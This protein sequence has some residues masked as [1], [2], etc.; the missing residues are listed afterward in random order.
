VDEKGAPRT[1]IPV[2]VSRPT[3]PLT[4]SLR[5]FVIE[6]DGAGMARIPAL[7]VGVHQV[8]AGELSREQ[9]VNIPLLGDRDVPKEIRITLPVSRA[10]K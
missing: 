2:K 7:E 6:T 9:S 4:E 5:P 10:G 1:G 8:A 3:G